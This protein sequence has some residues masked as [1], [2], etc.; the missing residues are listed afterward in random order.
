MFQLPIGVRRLVRLL[1]PRVPRVLE[2]SRSSLPKKL[3]FSI[4]EASFRYQFDGVQ[5]VKN[6]F[7]LALYT[8]LLSELRPKTI[9]E[10]GSANGGSG[11]WFAAQSRGLGLDATVYSFDIEPVSGRNQSNLIFDFGD[12]YKLQEVKSL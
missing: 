8:M 1:V 12:I 5:C 7:D 4:Q 6:P 2:P 11:L 10:I 9:V 3:L